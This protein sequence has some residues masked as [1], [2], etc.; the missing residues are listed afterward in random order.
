MSANKWH[1]CHEKEFDNEG[2]NK[3]L[4]LLF[5]DRKKS[6]GEMLSWMMAKQ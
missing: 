6:V 2:I 1:T 3:Y 4:G 5:K